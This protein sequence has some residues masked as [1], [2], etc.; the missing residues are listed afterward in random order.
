MPIP[1]DRR[2]VL[3]KLAAA[4]LAPAFSGLALADTYPSR[5][6]NLVV[7]FAAGGMTDILGRQLGKRITTS[8]GTPAIVD[9]RL[10]AGGI[11]GADRVAKAPAD[12]YNLLITTTAHVVNPAITKKLPYDTLGDFTPIAMLARTPNVLLVHPGIPA[13]NLQELLAYA[14][15][16]GG[17]TYGSSG[18]GGMR[19]NRGPV[20]HGR[21]P[22]RE[23]RACGHSCACLP[24]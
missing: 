9:N 10:G 20:G 12:G 15:K 24:T 8:W 4:T 18:T 5:P 11:I 23:G 21:R 6:I 19:P 2:A 22:R 14:R 16:K 7:P 13:N 17:V 1:H 3:K